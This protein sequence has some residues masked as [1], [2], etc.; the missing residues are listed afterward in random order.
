MDQEP[1][2]PG[3]QTGRAVR[4]APFLAF[5][6]TFLSFLPALRCGFVHWDDPQNFLHNELYRGFGWVNLRWMFTTFHTGPY[7]PLSW[8]TLAFDYK[9]W[10]MDPF[11]YHLTNVLLHS[12]NAGLLCAVCL[13]L[14]DGSPLGAPALF[15]ALFWAMH[16]LRVESVAWATE[17]RDV[18]SA[19]FYLATVLC[20]LRWTRRE[21]RR[22]WWAALAAYALSLLSKAMGMTLPLAL[23][24]L[25]A[26]PLRRLRDALRPR[27]REKLP[28]FALAAAAAIVAVWAQL[29][30]AAEAAPAQA[31]ILER[32]ARAAYGMVFYLHKTVLPWGLSPYYE[33]H[34]PF[35]PFAPRYALCGLLIVLLAWWTWKLTRRQPALAAAMSFYGISVLPVLGL[36]GLG[37]H[38][39]ADRYSY[40][41][42]MGFAVLAAAFLQRR[43]SAMLA[44]GAAVLLACA[45]L[46]W[47][48]CRFWRDTDR[49]WGRVLA[50]TPDTA[51]AHHN[52]GSWAA[53][54]G[55]VDRA[56]R[57]YRTA[58]AIQGDEPSVRQALAG[59]LYNKGNGLLHAGKSA[60]AARL[61]QEAL[62]LK[63]DAAEAH[64]NLGLALSEAGQKPQACLHY[65]EAARL[66]PGFAAARYNLG[67]ALSD[68]G[69]LTEAEKEYQE[70]LR[71]DGKNL[72]ARFNLGNILARQG[73]YKEAAVEYSLVLKDSPGYPDA[74]VNLNKVRRLGAF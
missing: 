44:A 10:G 27:L 58:L 3:R 47:R 48:Q 9:L 11:G 67:N 8:L 7:Q 51:V 22:W 13:A 28:F 61:F 26:Y 6:A 57:H 32:M 5:L 53:E 29:R 65:R 18:L 38:L 54:S 39:A 64:N 70:T 56:V 63:P 20:Y 37:N 45:A 33:M 4:W 36:F 72:D 69:H 34:L 73:R 50:L 30:T 19:T 24:I 40:I 71:L 1:L 74:R 66:A 25:D 46:T 41:P 43:R 59:L 14:L 31:G 52:L 35:N 68:L 62:V 49:L 16:P 23:L 17:R 42:T 21:D 2:A 60:E 55:D 12:A 15:G